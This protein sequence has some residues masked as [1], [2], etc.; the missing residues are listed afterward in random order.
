VDYFALGV[1]TYEFMFGK[2]PYVGKTRKDIR[3]AII[4]DQIHI[5]KCD[6]PVGWSMEAADFINKLL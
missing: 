4:A 1:V 5:K 6:I 2:R 3:D